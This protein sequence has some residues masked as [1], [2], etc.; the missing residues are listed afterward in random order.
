MKYFKCG[1]CQEPYKVDETKITGL[2]ALI[3]CI[4]CEAK[5]VIEMG[6]ILITQSKDANS[7]FRLKMGPNTI[8]RKA[9]TKNSE[10]QLDDEYV[11]KLHATILLENIDNKLFIS[12]IDNGSTNGTFTKTK[13][14]LKTGLKYRFLQDEYFI[15]GL[16]KLILKFN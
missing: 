6:P 7:K 12:I 9:A 8:G 2:Q 14:K 5:N 1:K 16:T 3:T 10:I 11:S 4:K 13:V 15:I